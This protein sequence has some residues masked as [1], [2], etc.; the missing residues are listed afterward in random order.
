MLI[1]TKRSVASQREVL[2]ARGRS[3]GRT[4]IFVPEVKANVATGITLLHVRFHDRLDAAT[5]RGVLQGYDRRYDRL[6]DWVTETEGAFDD[7]LLGELPVDDLLIEPISDAADHWRHVTVKRQSHALRR[8]SS[9]RRQTPTLRASDGGSVSGRHRGRGRRRRRRAVP[10]RCWRARRRCASG[11]SPPP[12]W[13]T[14]QP[15]LDPVPSLAAR[16]AAR[17]AV[18]KALGLGLGAFGF[19][20]VWVEVADGGAPSLVVTGRAAELAADRG[21]ASLAPVAHPRR[22]GGR[23]HGRRRGERRVVIP[24]VTP[25]EMAAIDAAAAGAGRRAHRAGRRGRRPRRPRR[26]S[27]APTAASST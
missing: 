22:P 2:V 9:S 26:C 4:V 15:R 19:H 16:F 14:S 23:R 5:M 21:V 27:A 24:I 25:E 18:M 10:A 11:C 6:V 3:D 8:A 20:E 1:G 17:E 7:R 13:P 12:S